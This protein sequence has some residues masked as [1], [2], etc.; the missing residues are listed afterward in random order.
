MTPPIP[1]TIRRSTRAKRVSV[2]VDPR[3]G[4]IEVVLPQRATHADAANALVELE[5]WIARQQA[6][7]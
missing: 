4:G 6:K 5:P 2:R 3:D 1:H 7:L